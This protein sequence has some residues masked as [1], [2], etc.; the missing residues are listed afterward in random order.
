MKLS[1]K[2]AYRNGN[3]ENFH[4]IVE[5]DQFTG[6]IELIYHCGPNG[7]YSY[8]QIDHEF[9]T[10]SDEIFQLVLDKLVAVKERMSKEE[11]D[12]KK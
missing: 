6:P 8:Y 1:L 11:T 3:E 9:G 7:F 2:N 12:E 10:I 5:D 4:I